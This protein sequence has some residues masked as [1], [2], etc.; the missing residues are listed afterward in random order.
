ME[1]VDDVL[2]LRCRCITGAARI[3]NNVGGGCARVIQR[4]SGVDSCIPDDEAAGGVAPLGGARAAGGRNGAGG[5]GRPCIIWLGRGR[6][7]PR[8]SQ[9]EGKRCQP[10]C[11]ISVDKL[12]R[13]DGT[14]PDT[15]LTRYV[16]YSDL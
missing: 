13:S 8:M 7:M 2:N 3:N 5:P 1:G 12:S 16:P 15:A 4:E 9:H 10:P 11:L 6:I 14:Y